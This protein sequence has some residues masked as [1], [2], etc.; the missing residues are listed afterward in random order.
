MADLTPEQEQERL[1]LI[2]KQNEAAKDLLST[3]EKM[4]K[5]KGTLTD[6]ERANL[7]IAK[8]LAKYS[9][10][11]EKSIQKRLDETATV[12]SLTKTLGELQ[13]EY[14]INVQKSGDIITK[15]NK[16]R[17]AAATEIRNLAVKELNLEAQIRGELANQDVIQDRIDRL[18]GRSGAAARA[19]LATARDDLRSSKAAL[20]VL[21]KKLQ[22]T[23]KQKDEQI[24]LTKQLLEAKKAHDEILQQQKREIEYA[25]QEV[26]LRKQKAAQEAISKALGLDKLKETLTLAGLM[27]FIVKAALRADGQ[28]VQLG[29]SLGVSR[30][31]AYGLRNEFVQYARATEDTFVTTTRL[32]KAQA[33]LTEQLGFAVMFGNQEL[34]TFARLTEQ[35]GLTSQEAGNLARFSAVIGMETKDYVTSI[36]Q[37]AFYAQQT[38]RTH[39]SDKQILQEI[40]K[41]SAGTLIKFQ[42]NPG[43]IGQAVV[44]AKK[45]GSSLEQI[46]KIGESLLNW[47]QS[48][49]NE[50]EAELITGRKINVEKARYAA[51][52]GN[53]LE[54]TREIAD[55]V[56]TL[57][58]FTNMNVIAQSSL[59]KAF[60]LSRD[61]MSE[62]LLKQE[63]INSYGSEAAK[64]NADQLKDMKESGLSLTEYLDKQSQQRS[65]QEKF[66]DA[67]LKLQDFFGE[68]VAGPFGMFLQV[69]TDSLTALTSIALVMGT[70][71]TISKG[72][73]F[74]ESMKL[75]FQVASQGIS[76]ADLTIQAARNLMKGE[77]LA[78]QIG[79]AAAWAIA[80]PI[81][82]LLGLGVALGVGALVYSQ[83]SKP[84]KVQDGQADSSRGP[85]TITDKF[86]ATAITAEGDGLAVSPNIR[87]GGSGANI[88]PGTIVAAFKQALKEQGPAQAVINGEDPFV[89][90][91]ARNSN[92]G[93]RQM[94]EAYRLA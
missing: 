24:A 51:L 3:Y 14:N 75:G 12:K 92:F 34:E 84:Q 59:A 44:E 87:K 6:D 43:A 52:T 71:W 1:E 13:R 11:I 78:T 54:L 49:E 22:N 39:F 42:K 80:N 79:I 26:A 29:K 94:Q 72:I 18:R 41:L 91:L 61:E 53:Q 77:E 89:D 68:L 8:D 65:V 93:K 2:Q 81:P 76:K 16:D 50:L 21:E 46:D 73:A 45:L 17:R 38:T 63:A 32:A 15:I 33:E 31:M 90:N 70:I 35:V 56:G 40:S 4:R 9:A 55:Q 57:N 10:T 23:N 20:S 69:L 88:A 48:I 64:L 19:A 58:D 5:V 27:T 62:M 60:G 25:K 74:F 83:M 28:A 36:R 66:N 85:F 37:S 86:G 7:N 30:K 82:A 67:V 47:E